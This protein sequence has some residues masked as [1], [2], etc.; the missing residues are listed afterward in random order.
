[1]PMTGFAGLEHMTRD[2]F[3]GFG[4]V[5][6]MTC[7]LDDLLDHIIVAM[8]KAEITI[9]PLLSLLNVN[10]KRDYIVALAGVAA[11]PP[12][13]IDGLTRLMK[14]TEEAFKLRN[15]IAHNV[16]RKGRRPGTIKPISIR[17]RRTLKM[18]GSGHN[19]REWT[20]AQLEAEARKFHQLGLELAQFMKQYGLAP[21]PQQRSRTR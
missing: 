10:E 2:H 14:R 21:P 17:A 6:T 18:L 19:E 12:Y 7:H 5:I 1:M 20:A 4:M 13:A 16:W 9:A 8:T 11:W 3:A 15:D